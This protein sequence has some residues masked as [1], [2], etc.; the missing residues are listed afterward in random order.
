MFGAQ[1]LVGDRPKC[2]KGGLDALKM[3]SMSGV[4]VHRHT[5]AGLAVPSLAVALQDG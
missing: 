5:E 1:V 4:D 3:Q 2:I